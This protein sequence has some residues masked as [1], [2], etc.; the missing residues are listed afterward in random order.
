MVSKGHL[1]HLKAFDAECL[2][3]GSGR[4]RAPSCVRINLQSEWL[5]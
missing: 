3:G 5:Q 2:V 1:F 4:E